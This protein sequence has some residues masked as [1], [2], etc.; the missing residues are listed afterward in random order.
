MKTKYEKILFEHN[1]SHEENIAKSQLMS[2]E[3]SSSAGLVYQLK[4]QNEELKQ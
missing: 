3:Y 2:Q 1:R 4:Q